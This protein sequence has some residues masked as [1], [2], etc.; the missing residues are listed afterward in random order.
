MDL[1][2]SATA[3][4]IVA[5]TVAACLDICTGKVPNTLTVPL[6]VVGIILMTFTQGVSGLLLS[7]EGIGVALALWI[8]TTLIGGS[9]GGGDIKLLAVVGALAGPVFVIR[10]FVA[11]VFIGGL[12]AVGVA[13]RHGV[14]VA[15]L[16]RVCTGIWCAAAVRMPGQI[17]DQSGRLH[18]PYAPAIALGA[19]AAW[20]WI[21]A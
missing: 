5:V 4:V 17:A 14:L 21:G 15:S 2:S 3:I 1:A 8:V 11:A 6:I 13:L 20:L 9:L 7:L 19:M 10:V 16:R 12:W 18:I